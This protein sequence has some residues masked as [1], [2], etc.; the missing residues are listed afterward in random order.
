MSPYK[1]DETKRPRAACLNVPWT[2]NDEA[3]AYSPRRET[4]SAGYGPII[5]KIDEL[6][7]EVVLLIMEQLLKIDPVTLFGSVTGTTKKLRALVPLVRGELKREFF[8]PLED[9][10]RLGALQSAI[11]MFPRVQRLDTIHKFPIHYLVRNATDDQIVA[12][13]DATTKRFKRL[14]GPRHWLYP[15]GRMI[16]ATL[17]SKSRVVEGS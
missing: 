6:P 11:R 3:R 4:M 5:I 14:S 8:G 15:Q 13:L 10:A 12:L 2:G 1:H 17:C 7:T 16:W 9:K